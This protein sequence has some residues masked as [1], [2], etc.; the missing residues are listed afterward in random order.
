MPATLKKRPPKRALFLDKADYEHT[1]QAFRLCWLAK[2]LGATDQV[3]F[4]LLDA[5]PGGFSSMAFLFDEGA[6]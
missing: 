4:D 6:S 5:Y 3:L 2:S 1:I